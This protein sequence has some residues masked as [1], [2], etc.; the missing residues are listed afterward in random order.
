MEAIKHIPKEKFQ[1]VQG[2]KKITDKKL[3]TK[4]VS[5]ARGAFRR[6]AKNKSSIVG[7]VIIIVLLLFSLFAPLVSRYQVSDTDGYYRYV[8]PKVSASASGGFWDGTQKVEQSVG[9]YQYFL[10]IG[11]ESGREAVSKYYGTKTVTVMEGRIETTKT[12]VTFRK[13]TYNAVGYKFVDLSAKQYADLMQYQDEN[14]I[15][16]IYPIQNMSSQ[17]SSQQMYNVNDANYWYQ[18][19][20]S[21]AKQGEAVLDSDGNFIPIYSTYEDDN[22]TSTMRIAGDPGIEN[23]NAENRY[24]YA[25]RNQ[26][27]YRVRVCYYDYYVYLNGFEPV[28]ILGANGTGQDL[29]VCLASG[30]R[31]SFILGLAVA[32]INFIIGAIY[33]SIEGYYGGTADLVMERISDIL[34]GIPFIVMATLF[35]LHLAKTV[36][37]VGSLIFAFVLTGW[38]GT[39]STVRTQFYRFKNQEYVLAARTLGAKDRRLIWKHIFPNALGT[40]VT[41]AALSIPSVIFSESMLSYL[42]IISLDDPT[43]GLT[44]LGTLLSSAQGNVLSYPH[45]LLYPALVISLLMISFNLLGNGLRDAFNP[46]LNGTDN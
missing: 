10:A 40:I 41:S 22:Y 7:M 46:T 35:N 1:F 5:F 2:D 18:T 12:V 25:S 30:T 26:T 28:F 19:N 9:T 17:G 27:G 44:S 13:D 20:L 4:P 23:P 45:T 37:V 16:V 38:I 39:A 21:G 34:S 11:A 33:G 31:F 32:L 14:H 29:F 42:G 6:F 43:T 8:L 15:Q 36:G 3:D 24:Y